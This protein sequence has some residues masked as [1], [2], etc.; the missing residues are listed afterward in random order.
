MCCCPKCGCPFSETQTHC[1][2]CGDMTGRLI[3]ALR[4]RIEQ[5]EASVKTAVEDTDERLKLL[6][7]NLDDD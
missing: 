7:Y 2:L 1:D 4:L 3:A 6:E 5:L